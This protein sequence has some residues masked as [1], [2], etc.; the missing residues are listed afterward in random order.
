[1]EVR[2]ILVPAGPFE[3]AFEFSHHVALSGFSGFFF[4]VSPAPELYTAALARNN[5]AVGIVVGETEDGTP[6]LRAVESDA[7]GI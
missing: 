5:G 7:N 2:R 3:G 1:M 4:N 6:A